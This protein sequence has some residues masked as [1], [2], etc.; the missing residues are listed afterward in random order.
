MCSVLKIDVLTISLFFAVK[1]VSF[2]HSKNVS[3]IKE[4]FHSPHNFP[5]SKHFSTV[6]GNFPK[7]NWYKKFCTENLIKEIFCKI[8]HQVNF[9]Q[10]RNFYRKYLIKEIFHKK[11]LIKIMFHSQRNFSQKDFLKVLDLF[12]TKFHAKIFL[13]SLMLVGN[14]RSYILTQ[15]ISF[16][17]M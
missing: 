17:S 3:L 15:K 5:W 12:N 6:E 7:K 4:F 11:N 14:K 16:L 1:K 13:S 2:P 9:P 8:F 10:P